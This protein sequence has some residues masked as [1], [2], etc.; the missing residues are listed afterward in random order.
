MVITK[1]AARLYCGRP[2]E[3]KPA[4]TSREKIKRRFRSDSRIDDEAAWCDGEGLAIFDKL[5]A[6]LARLAGARD[7]LSLARSAI[8][9]RP[10]LT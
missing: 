5:P 4:A 6:D 9:W 3:C 2:G 1:R 8:G 10:S 7:E